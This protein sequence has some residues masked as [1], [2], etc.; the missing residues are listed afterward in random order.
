M[1]YTNIVRLLNNKQKRKAGKLKD[2]MLV[3]FPEEKLPYM[4]NAQKAYFDK[5]FEEF[6]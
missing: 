3:K 5:L 6:E 1:Y 4:S 2:E